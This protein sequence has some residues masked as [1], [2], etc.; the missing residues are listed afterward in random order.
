[1]AECECLSL[2][3]FFHDKLKNMPAMAEI[4]KRKYCKGDS[5]DCARHQVFE[6]L[7]SENVPDDLFPNQ[8]EK[9]VRILSSYKT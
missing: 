1:M 5:T 8:N 6:K 3:P 4:Y 2:C 7:G 9:A